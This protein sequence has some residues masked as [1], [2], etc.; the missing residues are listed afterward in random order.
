MCI[1]KYSSIINLIYSGQ[2]LFSYMLEKM[3]E[4]AVI[5]NF[6]YFFENKW[7]LAVGKKGNFWVLASLKDMVCIHNNLFSS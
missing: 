2:E 4:T 1:V 6:L 7:L 3:K 5:S